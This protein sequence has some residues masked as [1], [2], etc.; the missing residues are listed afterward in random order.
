MSTI[1]PTKLSLS[2]I[3]RQLS[4]WQFLILPTKPYYA[5][6]QKQLCLE[7]LSELTRLS[8]QFISQ[9]IMNIYIYCSI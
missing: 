2:E 6:Q 1:Q 4:P 7:Y 3:S 8:F 9:G 5:Q